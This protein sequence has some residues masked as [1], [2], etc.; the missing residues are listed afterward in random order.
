MN[1]ENLYQIYLQYPQ[2]CTDSRKVEPGC[3]FFALKGEN[4]D[5]N[6]FASKALDAGAAYAVIDDP[7]FA[8]GERYILVEDTLQALQDLARYHR[9]QLKIPVLGITGTNGKTTTKELV[10]SVLSRKFKTYATQGNLNNHIGVPLTLLAIGKDIELA[11]IEMGANHQKEIEFLSRI[12]KPGCGMITNIGKA[13]LEGF[14]G[15]EGVKIAKSELY[16]F[17]NS[18][19]GNIFINHDNPILSGIAAEK[20]LQNVVWY[21]QDRENFV[22]GKISNMQPFLSV[23]WSAGDSEKSL[24]KSNLTGIYNFENIMAAVCIGSFFKLSPEQINAGIADYLPANSRSQIIQSEKNTIISDCYN[25]NPSSMLVALENLGTFSGSKKA[26]I[27]GDMFELGSEAAA[28]HRMV[29]EQAMN[30]DAG[31]RIFIGE[32]FYKYRSEGG[33]FFRKTA[34]A[35]EY[36]KQETINSRTILVKG[37]RS[38]QLEQLLPLL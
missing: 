3:L 24:A 27:L 15:F 8:R 7:S 19:G 33:L 37:S 20:N 13:H 5:A 18:T 21:G 9:D 17:L 2:I 34:E 23:E 10:N 4:F 12:A 6:H 22:S 14:G 29:L 25:A 38:M 11:I 30:I 35:A 1:P 31:P 26:I 16:N 32:E 28:E 36:L